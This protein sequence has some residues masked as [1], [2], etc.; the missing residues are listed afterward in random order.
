MTEKLAYRLEL[1]DTEGVL[2]HPQTQP[3]SDI[4][5]QK[6]AANVAKEVSLTAYPPQ[7][8]AERWQQG[9]AAVAFWQGE[10]VSYI[11]LV[12]VFT[13][14]TRAKL[15]EIMELN[16]E[17]L[18]NIDINESATGWTHPDWRRQR[19]SF[20]L[21][22]RLLDCFS[23]T[24]RLFVTIAVGLG[25][26]PVVTRLGWQLVPWGE[27]AYVS[28]LVGLP[29]MAV[30]DK[31]KVGRRLPPGMKLYRGATSTPNGS[32]PWPE[33]CHFW[34]SDLA[35]AQTLNQQLALLL[36]QDLRRWREAFATVL[37]RDPH[38]TWKPFLFDE[39]FG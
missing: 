28:S 14:P 21:R 5:W 10:I 34:V 1:S 19:L 30:A 36:K 15:A 3:I 29:Q 8:L 33:F 17:Q 26:A 18:P 27:V 13:A 37:M 39:D 32:Q 9:R 4:I 16:P 6:L 12:P 35:L 24:N 38:P 23:Q 31:I 22:Q 7:V 11:S 25:A 2:L 20:Q